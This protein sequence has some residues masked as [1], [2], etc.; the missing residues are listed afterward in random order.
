M[1]SVWL[2][3]P[4][5]GLLLP[6]AVA[7]AEAPPQRKPGLWEFAMLQDGRPMP[8]GALQVC[9]DATNADP[10]EP[11]AA[12]DPMKQYCKKTGVTK[13]GDKFVAHVV[14]KAPQGTMT[15]DAAVTGD[16]S[17][18]YRTDIHTRYDPP[19]MG[20]AET[21][22]TM[23]AKWLGPCKPGQK[24]GVVGVKGAGPVAPGPQQ[25]AQPRRKLES[26]PPQ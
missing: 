14:C 25:T 16:L 21:D 15:T 18:A 22:I 19:M 13:D 20:R 9:V 8:M 10:T 4:V 5:I 3:L 11:P 7:L 6:A 2:G 1:R 23:T 24:A 17:S 12:G 26:S